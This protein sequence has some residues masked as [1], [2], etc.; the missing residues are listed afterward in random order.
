MDERGGFRDDGFTFRTEYVE[1]YVYPYGNEIQQGKIVF[2]E[3]YESPTWH[4]TGRPEDED[5]R[6]DPNY[7]KPVKERLKSADIRIAD[8][9]RNGVEI[10]VMSLTQPGVQLVTDTD[11][12]VKIAHEMNLWVYEN[13]IQKYPDRFRAFAAVALQDPEEAAKELEFCVKELGFVGA[14]VN[15]YT[16]KGSL[17]HVEYLDEPQNTPFW[18][19]L[20][21]LDVPL[22]LH[23][24]DPALSEQRPYKGYEGLLGSAWGFGQCTSTHALRLMCSSLFDEFPTAKVILGH[25]GE[26][27]PFALPRVQHRLNNQNPCGTHKKPLPYYF[28]NNFYVTTS[29]AFNTRQFM[30]TLEECDH[31]HVLFCADTPYESLDEACIWFDN[32]PISY[33]DRKR[34]AR[35]NAIDLLKLD[36]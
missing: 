8:M 19:K 4:A 33:N 9:D 17:D 30:V 11:E 1:D 3:H 15:G 34:I 24:R 2:E 7:Y 21:E 12:A 14:L 28:E 13:Y 20:V 25:L 31:H 23:P 10:M 5:S 32:V 18:K 6:N 16:N 22:Y 29:G 26:G 35:Q 27:L 36:I